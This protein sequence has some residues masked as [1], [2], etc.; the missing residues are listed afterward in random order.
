MG[1]SEKSESLFYVLK[2]EKTETYRTKPSAIQGVI[3]I[4]GLL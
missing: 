1:L 2:Y 3:V 4:S